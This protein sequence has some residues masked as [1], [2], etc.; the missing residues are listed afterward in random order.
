MEKKQNAERNNKGGRPPKST[1][2]KLKYRVTVKLATLDYYTL[3]SRARSA[4]ISASEYL[5]ECFRKGYVRQRLTAEHSDYIR[6]LCGMANNLNQLAHKANAGGF[7]IRQMLEGSIRQSW[8]AVYRW[9]E[10]KNF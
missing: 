4:G 8:N 3:K 5:R 10:S 1:T 6:K 7:L 2:D 9:Q